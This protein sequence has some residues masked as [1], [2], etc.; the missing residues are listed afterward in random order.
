MAKTHLSLS[1]DPNLKGAPTGKTFMQV[2][3]AS[4]RHFIQHCYVIFWRNF[5]GEDGKNIIFQEYTVKSVEKTEA[6]TI[7]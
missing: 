3:P 4:I 6:E 1:D 7:S 5:I 2:Q